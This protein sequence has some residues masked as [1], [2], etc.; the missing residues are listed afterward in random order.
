M[1]ACLETFHFAE[2]GHTKMTSSPTPKS[3]SLGAE[4]CEG[5]LD[6]SAHPMLIGFG[7]KLYEGVLDLSAHPMLGGTAVFI[8]F[9]RNE[10]LFLFL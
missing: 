4:L 1:I 2:C 7:L 9:T 8:N 6:V 3:T 5:V 10:R